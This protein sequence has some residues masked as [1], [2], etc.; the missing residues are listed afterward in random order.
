MRL[1]RFVGAVALGAALTLVGAATPAVGDKGPPPTPVPPTGSPSPFPQSLDVAENEK[2]APKLHAKAALVADLDSGQILYAT[3]PTLRR[4]IA[5]VTKIMTALITLEDSDLSERVRISEGATRTSG[6]AGLSTLP[7]EVG[8]RRTV[9][10]LLDALLIQSANDAAVALAEHVDGSVS[11]FV[12]HM[13]RRAKELGM[14]DTRFS[15]PNGLNDA[16]YSTAKDLLMLSQLAMS[17]DT[18]SEIVSTKFA[19]IP[20]PRGAPRRIQNRNVLL[21]L[22]PGATG[23]KTGF[24]TRAG[25]CIVASA[26]RHG[27]H[28]IAIVLGDVRP[29]Y[30]DA[31]GLLNYGFKGFEEEMVILSGQ[32]IG[33]RTIDGQRV[34]LS[35][36]EPLLVWSPLKGRVRLTPRIG[37][38]PGEGTVVASVGGVHLG[39]VPLSM[40]PIVPTSTTDVSTTLPR[41]LRELVGGA[42]RDALLGLIGVHE[43]A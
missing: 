5:S 19:T 37:P 10:E 4:P 30:D 39:E 41:D 12:K 28:L 22:Y 16:G 26:H 23:I 7:L 17:N 13:N 31:A 34:R 43:A 15:S 36:T 8:E 27:R 9:A 20:S 18:F 42:V 32:V 40:T 24:T 35:A 6:I 33:T 14:R 25:Y 11:A 1:Q 21:W 29:A 38:G 2:T 3:R